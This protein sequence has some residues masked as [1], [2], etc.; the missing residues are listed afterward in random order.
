MSNI[1]KESTTIT[2]VELLGEYTD[3]FNII[4][5]YSINYDRCS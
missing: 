1:Q 4:Y 5:I 2:G 3:D